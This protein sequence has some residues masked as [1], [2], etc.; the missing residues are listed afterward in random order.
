MVRS[1]R[2]V[3]GHDRHAD[4]QGRDVRPRRH[5]DPRPRRRRRHR[6]RQRHVLRAG[7]ERVGR[8]RGRAAKCVEGIEAGAVFVNAMVASMPELPFG[9]IKK[10]GYGRELSELG[11]RSS[12]TPRPSTSLDAPGRAG[13][14]CTPPMT[15]L[16]HA[17]TTPLR[18]EVAAAMADV[19][20]GVLGNPTGSHPPAQ[21]ARRLLEE[22]RDEVAAF[23]GR[24][25]G[26][27]VF[28]SGGTESANLAFLGPAEAARQ[29]RGEAVLLSSAVEHPAVREAARAAA[30]AGLDTRELPVDPTASSTPTRSAR[31]LSSRTHEC[32]HHDGQQRDRRDPAAGRPHRDDQPPGSQRVRVHRRRPGR[33]L[34]RPGRGTAGRGHGLA[35]ARTRSAVPSAWARSPSPAASCSSPASTAGDRSAN[36]AAAPRTWRVPWGWPRRCGW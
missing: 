12:P 16:D 20:D 8:R 27:I 18:P 15:Y 19:H 35:R 6:R 34:C 22:A 31:T 3:G 14:A 5:G 4:R 30:K 10:S 21:R 13:P 1:D 9:G 32:R 24:D 36:G 23:L 17:A 33:A 28:T 7:F 25:P 11:S 26:D 29:D 2:P